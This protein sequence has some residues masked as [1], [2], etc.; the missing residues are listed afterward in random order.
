M[1]RNLAAEHGAPAM[2]KHIY[3]YPSDPLQNAP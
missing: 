1:A 3:P 2:T